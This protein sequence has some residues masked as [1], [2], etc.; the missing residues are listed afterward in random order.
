VDPAQSSS[1]EH[2]INLLQSLAKNLKNQR[3]HNGTLGLESLTLSFKLD[4]DGFPT[5]CGQYERTEANSLVEEVGD[6]SKK[7]VWL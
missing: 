1:I 3:F 2:D 4:E 6:L 5:D 7:L